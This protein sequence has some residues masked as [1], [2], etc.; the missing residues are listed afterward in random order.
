MLAFTRP[1]GPNYRR[2]LSWLMRSKLLRTV[3]MFATFAVVWLVVKPAFASGAPVCDPR[4]ATMFAPP[5]QIQDEERSLDVAPDCDVD[6][7]LDVRSV[8]PRR[9]GT[10]TFSISQEPVAPPAIAL[11]PI[12]VGERL[13]S[14]APSLS[15]PLQGVRFPLE[16]PPRI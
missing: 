16:R 9:G 6:G 7:P 4:G 5:P 8:T 12:S 1:E 10:I 11:P 2:S 15:R 13:P 14:P 3:L